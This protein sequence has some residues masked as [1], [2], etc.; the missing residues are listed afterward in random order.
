M[1]PPSNYEKAEWMMHNMNSGEQ[2]FLSGWPG[3]YLPLGLID[4]IYLDVLET[5]EHTRPQDVE[6]SIRELDAK[7]VR[8]ILWETHLDSPAP[9]ESPASY[10]LAE[11]GQ[12]MRSHYRRVGI[13][14]NGDEMWKRW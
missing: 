11:F 2:V 14:S 13:F 1:A 12:Y 3:L 9:L 10:H 7:Q 4:P 5:D 6:Q 8:Y